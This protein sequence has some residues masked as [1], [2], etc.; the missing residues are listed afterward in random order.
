MAQ[1]TKVT[2]SYDDG[3][4]QDVTPGAATPTQSVTITAGQSVEVIAQWRIMPVITTQIHSAP[5]TP[6]PAKGKVR[7]KEGR[8]EVQINGFGTYYEQ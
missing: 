7:I 5:P 1:I 6:V 3:T 8:M 2:V 4:V